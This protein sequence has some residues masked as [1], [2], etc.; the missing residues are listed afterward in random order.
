MIG[1]ALTPEVVRLTIVVG[2]IISI[3]FYERVQLTT[4]SPAI[5][6]HTLC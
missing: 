5:W 4:G 2:V 6:L 1:Y 3:V